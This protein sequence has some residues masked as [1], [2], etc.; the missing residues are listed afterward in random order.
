MNAPILEFQNLR[1]KMTLE[2]VGHINCRGCSKRENGVCRVSGK[3]MN[4]D[5][6]TFSECPMFNKKTKDNNHA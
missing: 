3:K 6:L 5:K 4:H 2:S 1:D